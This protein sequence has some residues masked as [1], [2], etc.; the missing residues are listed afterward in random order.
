MGQRQTTASE[1]RF[2]AR[3][4]VLS[5][6]DARG[7]CRPPTFRMLDL[8]T[9]PR[10]TSLGLTP[11]DIVNK[12]QLI[13]QFLLNKTVNATK[14]YAK[15]LSAL[16]VVLI[17]IPYVMGDIMDGI[18]AANATQSSS[19]GSDSDGGGGTASSTAAVFIMSAAVV[20]PIF[21]LCLFFIPWTLVRR[22]RRKVKDFIETIG[23]EDWKSL[24][25]VDT[26]NYFPPSRHQAGRMYLSVRAG[27]MIGRSLS[28]TGS[29]MVGAVGGG[30][31]SPEA[32]SARAAA[33]GDRTMWVT[34][35]Q[36]AGP[37]TRLAATAPTGEIIQVTVPPNTAPGQQFLV[38]MGPTAR[39]SVASSVQI[40]PVQPQ[41]GMVG[42]QYGDGGGDIG[43][44]G[45]GSGYLEQQP[46]QQLLAGSLPLAA[47]ALPVD[48]PPH[49]PQA[50]QI[51]AGSGEK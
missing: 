36:D 43:G 27:S 34:C 18:V 13:N 6:S 20:M 14:I 28:Q 37:G 10:L 29:R 35:P 15:W 31:G 1:L 32:V 41:Q 4:I 50:P 9:D 47:P 38:R 16:P 17:V 45:S 5:Q 33:T 51:R 21:V 26:V 23:F 22:Q 12:F 44:G 25:V 30:G 49:T 3:D 42:Q 8:A 19:S 39:P 11:G 24:G 2:K 46:R 40:L 7:C 48:E